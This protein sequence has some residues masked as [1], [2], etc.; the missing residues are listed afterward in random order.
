MK[1]LAKL[2]AAMLLS[3]TA[4]LADL[5]GR[6]G[7]LAA[8]G[9]VWRHNARELLG[10]A[11][12]RAGDFDKARQYFDDIANDQE[13]PPDMRQRIQVML[14]LITS[15]IGAPPAEKPQG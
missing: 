5:E 13:S 4:T 1:A 2:R 3:A 6:V 14:A 12:W 8:T 10:L 7:D 11:A 9:N 15:R